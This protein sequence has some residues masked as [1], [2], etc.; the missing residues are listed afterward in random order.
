MVKIE[1]QKQKKQER[2]DF[3]R[4]SDD[5]SRTYTMNILNFVDDA[6]VVSFSDD[7][8]QFSFLILRERERER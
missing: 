4:V 5:C 8:I 7:C 2:E 3:F 1:K 6:L